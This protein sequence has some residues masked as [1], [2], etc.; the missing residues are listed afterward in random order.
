M[1]ISGLAP[2][3]EEVG[4]GTKYFDIQ[5]FAPNS[6]MPGDDTARELNKE[7]F[8]VDS[9]VTAGSRNIPGNGEG[10]LVNSIRWP[11]IIVRMPKDIA[12]KHRRP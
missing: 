10:P 8:S 5:K 12:P 6:H 9:A 3:D 11:D 1:E 4:A 2:P 7:M